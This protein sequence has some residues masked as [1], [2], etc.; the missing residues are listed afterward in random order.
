MASNP[1]KSV[2]FAQELTTDYVTVYEVLTDV[3]RFGIDAVVFNNYTTSKKDVSVRFIRTGSGTLNDEVITNKTIR[4][5]DNFL[6]P[7]MIG[8]GLV[9]GDL[10][11]AKASANTSVTLFITGTEIT[12]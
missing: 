2:T 8:Q 12:N 6:A 4:K 11:Q 7:G 1:L 9:T 5:E 10:I 3:L